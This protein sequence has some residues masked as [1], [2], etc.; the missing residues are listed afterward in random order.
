M[1]GEFGDEVAGVVARDGAGRGEN[2]DHARTRLLRRRFY[3][4][5]RADEGN[6]G[7]AGAQMRQ[8]QGGGGV[9]GDDDAIGR[10]LKNQP[11]H[12]A[13]DQR[14][15]LRLALWPIGKAEVV[16]GIEKIGVRSLPQQ[17]A[18][19]RQAAEAGIEHEDFGTAIHALFAEDFFARDRETLLS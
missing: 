8:H 2:G 3:G 4:R 16:G 5:H 19:N 17:G 12:R 9:A 7:P 15:H 14:N 10:K 18:Q 11:L 6:L 1:V 13:Q